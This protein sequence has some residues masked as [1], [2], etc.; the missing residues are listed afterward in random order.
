M[1]FGKVF[2]YFLC[3]Y[4]QLKTLKGSPTETGGNFV[5]QNNQLTTLI[6]GPKIV[7]NA[8]WCNNNNLKDLYGFPKKCNSGIYIYNNPIYEITQLVDSEHQAKFIKWLNEYNVIK[9]DTIFEPGLDQAY[10]MATKQELEF[11]RK[12]FKNYIL[13]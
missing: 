1:K 11:D 2:G 13:I 7:G 10:Y 9:G 6:G 8:Y 4:N 5:C 12:V 3:G